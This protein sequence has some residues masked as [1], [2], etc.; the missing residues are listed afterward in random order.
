MGIATD[1]TGPIAGAGNSDWQV[2]QFTVEQINKNGGI[3][4]RPVELYLED[5]ALGSK[6]AVGNVR[7][8]I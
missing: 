3:L 4:G 2:A 6:I 1:I 7:R 5:T 8:L